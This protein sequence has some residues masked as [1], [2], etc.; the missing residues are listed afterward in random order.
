MRDEKNR[1]KMKIDSFLVESDAKIV[2]KA[3]KD[4]NIEDN[5]KRKIARGFQKVSK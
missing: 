2:L 1:K 3:L 5:F 4:K